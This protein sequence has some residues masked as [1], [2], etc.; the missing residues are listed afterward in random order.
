MNLEI[1]VSES[2]V[3][4][5]SSGVATLNNGWKQIAWNDGIKPSKEEDIYFQQ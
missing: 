3:K 1:S 4:R 2:M 5:T